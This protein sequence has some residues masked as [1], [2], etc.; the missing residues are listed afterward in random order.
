MI[1]SK[2]NNVFIKYLKM[3]SSLQFSLFVFCI[4]IFGIIFGYNKNTILSISSAFILVFVPSILYVLPMVRYS[5]KTYPIDPHTFIKL[6][7]NAVR[8]RLFATVMLFIIIIF[9]IKVVIFY[10]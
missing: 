9:F 10:Y 1:I 4:V 7:K 6:T 5:L 2:S 8:M 3:L